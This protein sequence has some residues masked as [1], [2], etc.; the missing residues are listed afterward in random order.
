L[1]SKARTF[2]RRELRVFAF[3]YA[4]DPSNAEF[5]LSYTV[6][7]LKKVDIKASNAHAED[8]LQ[9][10]LGRGNARLFLHELNTWM[11]SPYQK[12]KD[13]DENVQYE[14]ELPES[15]D[16]RGMPVAVRKV[17]DSACAGEPGGPS[18]GRER[19]GKVLGMLL[20]LP[21]IETQLGPLWSG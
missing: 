6:A 21:G 3:L 12:L 9:E 17:G 18:S 13:W 4:E 14:E 10:Y 19:G 2:I 1:Q 20:K 15:F 11:R 8:L 5:L 16:D 7:I